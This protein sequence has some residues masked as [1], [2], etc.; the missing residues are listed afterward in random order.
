MSEAF[1]VWS[2]PLQQVLDCYPHASALGTRMSGICLSNMSVRFPIRLGHKMSTKLNTED[3][4][5]ACHP[6]QGLGAHERKGISWVCYRAFL[7]S[8]T[9]LGHLEFK[10]PLLLN[11]NKQTS[12]RAA[13][14]DFIL[15]LSTCMSV[16]PSIYLLSIYLYLYKISSF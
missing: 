6:L 11:R 7:G 4:L 14:Y 8:R 10:F 3:W 9:L 12:P 15:C 5:L 2:V 1:L 16:H 13:F